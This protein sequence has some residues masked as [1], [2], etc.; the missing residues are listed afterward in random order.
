MVGLSPVGLNCRVGDSGVPG[1]ER[2]GDTIR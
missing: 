2:V 1:W